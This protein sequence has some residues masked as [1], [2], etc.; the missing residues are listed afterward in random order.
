MNS[1]FYCMKFNLISISIEQR[2]ILEIKNLKFFIF[3]LNEYLND[4]KFDMSIHRKQ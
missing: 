4:E 2:G 3:K 1:V